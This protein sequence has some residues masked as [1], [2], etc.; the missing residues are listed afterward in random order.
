[1]KSSCTRAATIYKIS[2]TRAE[3][4]SP[5]DDSVFDFPGSAA[6]AL[7]DMKALF[8]DLGK[9]QK[10]VDELRHQYT[11]HVTTESEL[12]DSKNLSKKTDVCDYD[13]IPLDGGDGIW[14]SAGKDGKP[15]EGNEKKKADEEFDKTYEKATKE[16][17]K[18]KA[19]EQAHPEKAAKEKAKEDKEDEA[20]ISSILRAEKFTNPRRERFQGQQVLAFDFAANPDYKPKSRNERFAQT[21]SG[22]VLVDEQAHEVVRLEAH[23]DTGFKLAGGLVASIGKGT[24]FVFEQTK[25]NDEVWLPSYTEIHIDARIIFLKA[26]G[27][28]ILRF[29]DYKKYNA[30]SKIVAVQ[31]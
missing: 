16:R 18:Q 13:V 22:V 29:T 2:V 30:S 3:V 26:R 21:L 15:L 14:R 25:V 19:D 4:N 5:V 28:A 7:P 27:N 31:P 20:D 6:V 11:Y 23:F 9:N 1:M 12:I 24:N 8:L 17:A 10:D